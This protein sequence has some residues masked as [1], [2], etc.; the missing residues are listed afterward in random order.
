M[1]EIKDQHWLQGE[2][3][4]SLGYYIR[5]CLKRIL[6]HPNILTNPILGILLT[7]FLSDPPLYLR[8][9]AKL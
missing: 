7:L 8:S 6:K 5:Y 2:L 1:P 3:Q 4:T 9:L